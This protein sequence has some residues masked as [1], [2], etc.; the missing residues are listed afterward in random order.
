MTTPPRESVVLIGATVENPF[1][2]VN[3]ALISRSQIFELKPLSENNISTIL[4]RALEDKERGLGE[5]KVSMSDKA[6]THLS[7]LSNGDARKALNS[8][9]I[10]V[11]TTKPDKK[12][13]IVF[14]EKVAEESIQ[15]KAVVYDK[16]GDAHY[17]TISAFIKSMRGSDP[18]AALYYLAKMIYAGEDPGS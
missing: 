12:G 5:F 8:L 17:D 4:R 10:G 1:F 11:L 14:D 6:L 3:S 7:R 15:K 13:V 9:E 16:K 18:D 2:Y